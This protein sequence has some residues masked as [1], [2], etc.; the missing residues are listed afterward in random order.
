[1]SET[2][3]GTSQPKSP[4]ALQAR[5]PVRQPAEKAA[6]NG[7]VLCHAAS[8][9]SVADRPLVRRV[10]TAMVAATTLP[11]MT[12]VGGDELAETWSNVFCND[13]AATASMP[14][15][16][17]AAPSGSLEECVNIPT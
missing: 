8:S 5:P 17:A 16:I 1:M 9:P 6:I 2:P 3:I 11:V 4:M 13:I 14:V 15:R 7:H 12:E 10:T